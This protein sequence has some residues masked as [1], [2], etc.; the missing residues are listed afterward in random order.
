MLEKLI[1]MEHLIY[2]MFLRLSL[3]TQ[4]QIFLA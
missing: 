3:S 1:V 4:A 2:P